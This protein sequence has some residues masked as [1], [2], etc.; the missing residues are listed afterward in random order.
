MLL[1]INNPNILNVIDNI[2]EYAIFNISSL[3]EGY[4]KLDILPINNVQYEDERDF[5]MQYFNWIFS[6]DYIFKRFFSIINLLYMGHKV[7]L[8]VSNSDEYN[9]SIYSLMK[10]IQQRYG[11]ISTYINDISDIQFI[12]NSN[13][14]FSFHGLYNLDMDKERYIHL[15][16]ADGELQ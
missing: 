3:K 5:D 7:I 13:S 2:E 6:N 15:M 14:E 12:D 9:V 16:V 8:L 10:M 4:P 11:Y 1:I